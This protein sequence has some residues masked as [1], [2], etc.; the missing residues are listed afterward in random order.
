MGLQG[1]LTGFTGADADH[2]VKR[3]DEDLSVADAAGL[4]RAA[5]GVD[6]FLDKIVAGT[7]AMRAKVAAA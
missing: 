1:G 2:L 5:D 4:G 7:E 3:S 6:G